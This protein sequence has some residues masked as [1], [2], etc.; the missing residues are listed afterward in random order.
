MKNHQI[1]LIDNTYSVAAAKDLLVSLLNEKIEYLNLQNF[2]MNE[3]YG[4]DNLNHKKQMEEFKK[5]KEQLLK[6]LKSIEGP[7]SEVE[8][9]CFAS[10]NVKKKSVVA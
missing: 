5:E 1:K 7:D 9:N 8:I 2:L 10:L 6:T 3:K 4:H